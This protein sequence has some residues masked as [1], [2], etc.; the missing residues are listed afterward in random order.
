MTINLL[1]IDA[2]EDYSLIN[3]ELLRELGVEI[4]VLCTTDREEFNGY[5]TK[6]KK[7]DFDELYSA[8]KKVNPDK[9]VCYSEELFYDVARVRDKL[10]IQGMNEDT[11]RLFSN[12]FLMYMK[13]DG[14]VR[15]PKTLSLFTNCTYFDVKSY[16][17]MGDVFIKPISCSGSFETYH[18][19]NE[20]CYK[21][22]LSNKKLSIELYI[23][24]NYIY[25]DLYHVEQVVQKGDIIF[26]SARMYS[27]PNNSMLESDRLLYSLNVSDPVI[28]SELLSVSTRVKEKIGVNNAIMHTE[29]FREVVS[30]DLIF[31]ETNIRSPGIGLNRMYKEILGISFETLMCLLVCQIKI[32]KL[33]PSNRIFACGYYPLK[34]GVVKKINKPRV[35]IDCE[36]TY[37][38]KE[39]DCN[40][41]ALSMSK[42]AMV[43]CS[44][45]SRYK[46]KKTMESLYKHQLME[47]I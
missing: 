18:I 38:A 41:E 33:V 44:D 42:A 19:K 43:V 1:C 11:A 34:K 15:V 37:F 21:R 45:L 28:K 10:N 26:Q 46:V 31:L 27:A 35:D 23:A 8:A 4:H 6:I 14:E 30:G 22:F 9:I 13:L 32:P 40:Q 36:I 47:V 16:L 20:D 2:F 3:R 17:G 5:Y 29:F 24:Q 39:G 25:G 12:K 7:F